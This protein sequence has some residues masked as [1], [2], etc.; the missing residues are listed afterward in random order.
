MNDILQIDMTEEPEDEEDRIFLATNK[1]VGDGYRLVIPSNHVDAAS[2]ASAA[3]A[4]ASIGQQL[5]NIF[6]NAFAP[7]LTATQAAAQAAEEERAR[8]YHMYGLDK[9]DIQAHD[10]RAQDLQAQNLQIREA[11]LHKKEV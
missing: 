8:Q 6:S 4:I 7:V 1:W 10:L 2:I 9:F 3:K 5:S 11:R